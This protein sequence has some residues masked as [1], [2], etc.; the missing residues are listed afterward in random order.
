MSIG[1]RLTTRYLTLYTCGANSACGLVEPTP[2]GTLYPPMT[3]SRSNRRLYDGCAVGVNL[4][5]H[6]YPG[7][8]EMC[9]AQTAMFPGSQQSTK[10]VF[11]LCAGQARAAT[12]HFWQVI[13][14]R[15]QLIRNR[16]ILDPSQSNCKTCPGAWPSARNSTRFCS[17]HV[18]KPHN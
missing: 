7:Y 12:K 16:M 15:W 8:K 11:F 10:Y 5:T 9:W 1:A 18:T 6:R 4:Q 3:A 17:Q 14:K 2:A 13:D